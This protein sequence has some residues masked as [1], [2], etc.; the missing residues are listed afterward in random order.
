MAT[1]YASRQG[2]RVGAQRREAVAT[3]RV[4]QASVLSGSVT[5]AS[6]GLSSRS[7]RS[8]CARQALMDPYR[9][10]SLNNPTRMLVSNKYFNLL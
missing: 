7:R 4:S 3:P 2:L 9:D 5:P 6:Q 8:T 1:M 10:E